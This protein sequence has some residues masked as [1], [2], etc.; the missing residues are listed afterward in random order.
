MSDWLTIRIPFN[1]PDKPEI[2][3]ILADVPLNWK[4]YLRQMANKTKKAGRYLAAN[5]LY[6]VGEAFYPE[7]TEKEYKQT[8]KKSGD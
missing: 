3:E 8:E 6:N 1:K 4:K 7:S 5:I 2:I